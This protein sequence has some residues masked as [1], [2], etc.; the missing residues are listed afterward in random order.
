VGVPRGDSDEALLAAARDG[1][2]AA[3][4]ALYRRYEGPLF[5]YLVRQLER[6][7]EAEEVFHETMLAVLTAPAPLL[8]HERAFA[9]WVYRIAHHR[10]AN[11][12]RGE[13]RAGR[14]AATLRLEAVDAGGAD[15]TTSAETTLAAQGRDADLRAA[16][17]R[18][19]PP[20]AAVY[21]LRREGLSYDDMAARLGV[22]VGTI[23]S[24]VSALVAQL[25]KE[26][27]TWVVR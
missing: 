8:A 19:S 15:E 2:P 21:A 24:R 25:R 12:R 13:R 3:Y 22:P 10:A 14:A 9:A 23:K 5:G 17:A 27:E 6:R 4:R 18:L 7:E 11:R 20:L 16:A 1:D 26:L